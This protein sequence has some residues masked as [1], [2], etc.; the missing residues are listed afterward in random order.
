M[1]APE[2]EVVS[3]GSHFERMVELGQDAIGGRTSASWDATGTLTVQVSRRQPEAWEKKEAAANAA[4]RGGLHGASSSMS[5]SYSM[6]PAFSPNSP[7]FAADRPPPA[8]AL[9][10]ASRRA[11]LALSSSSAQSS[12]PLGSSTLGHFPVS[13]VDTA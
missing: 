4:S 13:A 10:C 3:K 8:A 7:R 11:S 9:A 6:G 5:G 12:P 2:K 1:S